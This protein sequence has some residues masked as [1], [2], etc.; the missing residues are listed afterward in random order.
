MKFHFFSAVTLRPFGRISAMLFP[1]FMAACAQPSHQTQHNSKNNVVLEPE[2]KIVDYLSVSCERVWQ[3][4]DEESMKNPLY[5]MRAMDCGTRLSPAEARAEARQWPAGNWQN[6]FKQGVL[7][8][9]GNVTPVERRQY[10]VRLDSFS[11]DYPLSIRPLLQLWRDN[12][13][14]QL[15]LSADRG[16]YAQLQQTS[17]N[18]LDELRHNQRKLMRELADTRRKLESLT[19]IERQLSSRKSADV[20]DN[21]HSSDKSDTTPAVEADD[22][23]VPSAPDKAQNATESGNP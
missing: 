6:T 9:N 5:W 1:L 15:Q 21:S 19:D 20:S 2:I 13:A 3:I 18:Q 17:D 14:A 23:Y 7:L 11:V 12:Q 8:N 4:E 16:R 10:M 22:T